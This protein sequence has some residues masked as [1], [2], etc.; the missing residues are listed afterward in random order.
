L[1]FARMMALPGRVAVFQ[2]RPGD[3]KHPLGRLDVRGVRFN[4]AVLLDH[5]ITE[6]SRCR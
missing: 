5:S 3:V 4:H 6:E 2:G 1:V